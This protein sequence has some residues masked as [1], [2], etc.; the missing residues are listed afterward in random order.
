MICILTEAMNVFIVIENLRQKT[1]LWMTWIHSVFGVVV[2]N[3]HCKKTVICRVEARSRKRFALWKCRCRTGTWQ[4][5]FP[6]HAP[7][8]YTLWRNFQSI[9]EIYSTLL[10]HLESLRHSLNQSDHSL[11]LIARV[12]PRLWSLMCIYLEFQFAPFDAN[13]Y[14]DWPL[15]LR[16]FESTKRCKMS[17]IAPSFFQGF[18]KVFL[19]SNVLNYFIV[20]R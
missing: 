13:L 4:T 20:E 19:H 9:V 17:F 1:P 7:L 5:P 15:W 3:G 10:V 18:C 12:F 6:F 14:V 8:T 16:G 2:L 11:Q